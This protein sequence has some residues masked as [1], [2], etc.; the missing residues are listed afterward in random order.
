LQGADAARLRIRGLTLLP[1]GSAVEGSRRG[2]GGTAASRAQAG[3]GPEATTPSVSSLHT[4]PPPSEGGVAAAA[5][6]PDV[7]AAAAAA[8]EDQLSWR[9]ALLQLPQLLWAGVATDR[10]SST[11]LTISGVSLS[12]IT[13]PTTWRGFHAASAAVAAA[14]ASQAA[15]AAGPFAFSPGRSPGIAQQRE[16]PSPGKRRRARVT[17]ERVGPPPLQPARQQHA[18]DVQQLPPPSQQDGGGGASAD[19]WARLA[20]APAEEHILFRQWEACVTLCLLPPGSAATPRAAAAGAA[21]AE[22]AAAAAAPP[23]PAGP[24]TPGSSVPPAA[25]GPA[26]PPPLGFGGPALSGGSGDANGGLAY[27][28]N[29]S[30]SLGEAQ[31]D[32]DL[33]DESPRSPHRGGAAFGSPPQGA[34]GHAPPGSS[35]PPL[36]RT[37]MVLTEE[38]TIV[39]PAERLAWRAATAGGGAGPRHERSASGGARHRALPSISEDWQHAGA[40]AAAASAAAAAAAQHPQDEHQPPPQR[41]PA[42]AAVAT[43]DRTAATVAAGRQA[44][45]TAADLASDAA[46]GGG[47]AASGGP[48]SLLLDVAVSLKALV[49]ELNAASLAIATRCAAAALPALRGLL[50]L[51]LPGLAGVVPPPAACMPL[52]RLR[53]R[54]LHAATT[55]VSAPA[56]WSTASCTTSTLGSTGPRGRRCRCRATPPP[57]GSTPAGRWRGSAGARRGGRWRW[58]AWRRGVPPGWSTRACTPPP[59]PRSPASGSLGGAG[60]SAAACAPPPPASCSAWLSLRRG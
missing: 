47:G 59:T 38:H 46:G 54:R 19:C 52:G 35:P 25:D 13:F 21:A 55:T 39:T 44:A 22:R 26:A 23:P 60:G 49:P 30:L 58:Q 10:P 36:D 3:G 37:S 9:Q 51:R 16:R 8:A 18:Q 6:A 48:G 7:A 33:E 4:P 43:T 14:A 15:A 1:Q 28:Q 57:G 53:V 29:S 17:A 20:G 2:G 50:A 41:H 42:E 56:G 5:A 32:S 45:A 40:A 11:R 31:Y 34:N 12:L 27:R 24:A